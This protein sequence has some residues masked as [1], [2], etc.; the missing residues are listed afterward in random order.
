VGQRGVVGVGQRGTAG[1]GRT[2]E[3]RG[4]GAEKVRGPCLEARM[5]IQSLV[6]PLLLAPSHLALELLALL[7]LQLRSHA[8]AVWV[9]GG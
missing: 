7:L 5:E 2:P 4:A 3:L 6:A 8:R 1:E 9:M